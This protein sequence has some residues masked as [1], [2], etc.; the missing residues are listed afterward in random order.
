MK[1]ILLLMAGIMALSGCHS[2][3]EE[4]SQET[5]GSTD[6]YQFIDSVINADLDTLLNSS[7]PFG[8][9]VTYTMVKDSVVY[10]SA[11]YTGQLQY[12]SG[13]PA[14]P[15]SGTYWQIGSCTKTFTAM[16][17]AMRM[18]DTSFSVDDTIGQFV[19]NYIKPF[20]VSSK[21]NRI[22]M[23]NK[24][25]YKRLATYNAGFYKDILDGV[26][27][28]SP[29]DSTFK[30]MAAGNPFQYPPN[31]DTSIYSNASVALLGWDLTSQVA[32][33]PPHNIGA[34]AD[35]YEDYLN[36]S[37][38]TR[39][40]LNNTM[41][42]EVGDS[43]LAANS[44]GW[45]NNQFHPVTN[46]YSG[47]WPNNIPAGAI[48]TTTEDFHDYLLAY[49]KLLPNQDP[50]ISEAVDTLRVITPGLDVVQGEQQEITLV[51]YTTTLTANGNTYRLFVKGGTT[52]GF[53]T[54]IGYV[55]DS[56]QNAILGMTFHANQ[57]QIRPAV[58]MTGYIQ[59]L[60][61]EYF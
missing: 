43:S 36:D 15:N 39:I 60:L 28:Q 21:P 47:S 9:A 4:P 1:L 20:E 2:G 10:D 44:F 17:L 11:F 59:T 41:V 40:G 19:A 61:D 37:L 52:S 6:Y 56:N 50:V 51:W 26:N 46:H 24:I 55:L 31:S 32:T 12:G 57:T 54:A 13:A 22:N 25:S 34:F 35:L 53:Q 48:I 30:L 45:K 14:A 38:L 29:I 33:P 49:M 7:K 3:G 23:L 18:Q 5:A 16:L 42:Y 8:Y 58:H 27:G